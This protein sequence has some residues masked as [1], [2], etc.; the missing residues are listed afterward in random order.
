MD[1]STTSEIVLKNGTSKAQDLVDEVICWSDDNKMQLNAEKCKELRIS[2]NVNPVE[3]DSIVVNG[4][5]LEVV[6]CIKMLG[7]T[8]NSKLTWNDHIDDVVKKINKRLYFLSQLKRAKV[9]PKDLALFYTS[10]IRSVADYAIPAI[11]YSLPQ[12]LKN[13]LI[14]KDRGAIFG[15]REPN[16]YLPRGGEGAGATTKSPVLLRSF[17]T[18][19][20]FSS[21]I[22]RLRR[23][24]FVL[25]W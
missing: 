13:D 23:V 5:N 19:F 1:D 16:A 10:C 2:F 17:S 3:M 15:L 7:L 11:Y 6:Q 14:R 4:K 24:F 8:I 12:Y 22:L 18:F 21:T 9:K 25:Y 20:R